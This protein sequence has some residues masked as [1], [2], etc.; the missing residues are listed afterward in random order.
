MKHI[1]LFEN[2]ESGGKDFD[3]T[4]YYNDKS[5]Y[6]SNAF[7]MYKNNE[8]IGF[9]T[10]YYDESADVYCVSGVYVDRKYRGQGYGTFLYETVMT[11]VNPKGV[12]MTR[13]SMTSPDATDVW[14]KFDNRKDVKKERINFEGMT[15]KRE[16]LPNGFMGDE[17][18]YVEKMLRLEDT[19]FFYSYGKDKL[20]SYLEEPLDDFDEVLDPMLDKM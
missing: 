3:V 11:M 4:L 13:D 20:D 10:Y 16:D 7:L 1:K 15:H 14:E 6:S 5:S 18:E 9:I 12:T 17:T 19:R 8:P 2:W